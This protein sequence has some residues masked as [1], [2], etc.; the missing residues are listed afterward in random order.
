MAPRVAVPLR[1]LGG[2]AVD[3]EDAVPRADAVVGDVG[4]LALG[5]ALGEVPGE[6]VV[7]RRLGH[8]RVG[9]GRRAAPQER[10]FLV[11]ERRHLVGERERSG[12]EL[13][14]V[15]ARRDERVLR[16]RIRLRAEQRIELA[17][18]RLREHELLG[19]VDVVAAG[20]D[21]QRFRAVEDRLVELQQA[22]LGE[23]VV[24]E[25][26]VALVGGADLLEH[27]QAEVAPVVVEV[28]HA[29]REGR[30]RIEDALQPAFREL[31]VG[32]RAP[33][34]VVARPF[35][36][37]LG[38]E[39]PRGR[40]LE[41]AVAERV[42]GVDV[43]LQVRAGEAELQRDEA[44]REAPVLPRG[45]PIL[46]HRAVGVRR[47]VAPLELE[48]L[49]LGAERRAVEQRQLLGELVQ[50]VAQHRD[51]VREEFGHD[52]DHVHLHGQAFRHLRRVGVVVLDERDV[53]DARAVRHE[54][55]V[56]A[57]QVGVGGGVFLGIPGEV[58]LHEADFHGRVGLRGGVPLLAEVF[59]HPQLRVALL[60]VFQALV[61]HFLDL[62]RGLGPGRVGG[63]GDFVGGR[64]AGVDRQDRAELA[65]LVFADLE[66]V[67]RE[68]RRVILDLVQPVGVDGRAREGERQVL[69]A[70]LGLDGHAEVRPRGRIHFLDGE[71]IGGGVPGGDLRRLLH[72]V[73]LAQRLDRRAFVVRQDVEL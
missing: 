9:R 38:E 42:V 16:V 64:L 65:E 34:V 10:Q 66:A 7:E 39:V 48:L 30:E 47:R 3:V 62:V 23:V 69:A 35:G 28:L 57:R 44:G 2:G 55:V 17:H 52:L 5:E 18:A 29:L 56:V 53:A 45:G 36:M 1:V 63:A 46:R 61:P 25:R 13:R 49:R 24:V 12:G 60:G 4:R 51:A 20:G 58:A 21:Q 14:P 50:R 15:A 19:H 40:P 43:V 71:R 68:R 72:G 59:V 70:V 73:E 54:R 11:E 67:G 32:P 6:A 27:R 41:R 33:E 8:A 37:R 22:D 26:H 31:L